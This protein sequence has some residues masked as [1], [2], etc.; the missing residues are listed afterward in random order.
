M[1][2]GDAI[3]LSDAI[4]NIKK[5]KKELNIWLCFIGICFM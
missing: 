5:K 3:T 1:L 4:R 2:Q